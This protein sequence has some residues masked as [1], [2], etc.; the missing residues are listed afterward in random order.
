MS[1]EKILS[2]REVGDRLGQISPASVLKMMSMKC[3]P[4]PVQLPIQRAGWPSAE[5]QLIV[6]ALAIDLD[7]GD[8]KK[9]GY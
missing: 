9:I 1:S 4:R 6:D 3:L 2:V 5:I 8:L 7:E